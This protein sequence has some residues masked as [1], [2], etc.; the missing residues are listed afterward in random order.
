MVPLRTASGLVG[1]L[2]VCARPRSA[3]GSS[4]TLDL[5]RLSGAA[6]SLPLA[7]LLQ[8]LEALALRLTMQLTMPETATRVWPARTGLR[9]ERHTRSLKPRERQA[10][11]LETSNRRSL[12][13]MAAPLGAISTSS[14]LERVR[15]IIDPGSAP[16]P[17][18]NG[19]SGRPP[20][21]V[22]R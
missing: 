17:C 2:V 15:Q 16:L 13:E 7:D 10:Q 4:E 11:D 8:P 9:Q 18:I 3:R 6:P 12:D 14:A 22:W 19:V 5:S 21:R 1:A 20:A